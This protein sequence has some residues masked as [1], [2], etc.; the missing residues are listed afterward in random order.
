LVE[1]MASAHAEELIAPCGEGELVLAADGVDAPLRA[2]FALLQRD[3]PGPSDA[4]VAAESS[5]FA[6]TS[7][8]LAAAFERLRRFAGSELP[9]L[10]LGENGTGKELAARFVH[11]SSP[12]R[13]REMVPFNCAGLAE[14][15]QLS[16]LFGHA[17]GAF[18]GAE[19]AHAGVFEQ[20]QGTSLF[21]DEIGDLPASAQG[22][23]LR[24]LQEREIRRVG[25]SVPRRIDVRVI[26]ATNRDLEGMVEEGRF[27][28]DLFFRLKVA[29]VTLPPLRE[30]GDDVLLLAERFLDAERQ[31]RPGV[32]LTPEARRALRAHSWPGNVRELKHALEVAALLAD[33]GRIAPEHL[34]LG[35]APPP[36]PETAYHR[37]LEEARRKMIVEAWE[38]AGGNRAAAAR[39]LGMSRQNFSYLARRLGLG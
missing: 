27:R 12:R 31:R 33:D 5:P 28:Q 22:A 6:G 36:R 32:R 26:A 20:A 34:D 39:R 1:G 7:P 18:T 8:A 4:A 30:R 37:S 21:L 38:A 29:T 14:S 9:V 15:L 16:E 10:I 3:L 23:I 17:R 19:R 24:A 13:G 35:A 25:E 2:L 11:D